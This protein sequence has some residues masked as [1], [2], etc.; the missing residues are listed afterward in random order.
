VRPPTLR[1]VAQQAGVHPATA[2]RALNPE[3]RN[4]VNEDTA[5]RVMKV[6]KALGYRPNPIARSLKTARSATV[7]LMVP[8]LTNP[9]FPPIVRGVEQVLSPVGYS[10][11]IVNT[12]NDADREKSQVLSLRSRQ[13]EGFIMATA[14]LV[15]PLLEQL[16]AEGVPMVL[17]NRRLADGNVPSVTPDDAAGAA[18]AV[19]HL[20]DLGHTRIAHIAGPQDTSSGVARLRAYREALAGHGIAVD[21]SLIVTC[22]AWTE[23]EGAR[24]L[25]ELLDSGADF[26]AVLGGNDMIALGC[27]DVL[28]ERGLRC[29]GDLSVVGFN[30][31]PFVD[32]LRPPLTSIHVPH[33]EMGAEA[34][35]LLL[36]ILQN[37][38]RHP[39]SVLLPPSIAVRQSTAPPKVPAR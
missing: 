20:T 19:A 5:N 8:D 17:V 14:T 23:T 29:P 11:W 34:A 27:Y 33:Q 2:S 13:V 15:H 4:L 39:R 38:G 28:E 30:D 36:D 3:T 6:A 12:D 35:H 22:S 21:P 32:K 31:V 24:G 25:R 16:H 37:P 7:G 1:D 9:L 18:M 10:A 26:T